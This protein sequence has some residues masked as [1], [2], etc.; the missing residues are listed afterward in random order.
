MSSF[1]EITGFH[2][3]CLL[4]LEK[5]PFKK[6]CS[7]CPE[8]TIKVPGLATPFCYIHNPK[9]IYNSR[10]NFVHNTKQKYTF[11]FITLDRVYTGFLQNSYIVNSQEI[12]RLDIQSDIKRQNNI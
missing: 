1:V 3:K 7:S 9:K 10:L 2:F 4:A 8:P 11:N 5:S 12:R 6:S